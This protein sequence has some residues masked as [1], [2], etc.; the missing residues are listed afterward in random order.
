MPSALRAP[1][2]LTAG[3]RLYILVANTV[4]STRS[5]N[6]YA[7]VLASLQA[8][9]LAYADTG[10]GPHLLGADFWATMLPAAALVLLGIALF[11]LAIAIFAVMHVILLS[12]IV[13][14]IWRRCF[15]RKGIAIC[16]VTLALMYAALFAASSQSQ[17]KSNHLFLRQQPNLAFNADAHSCH[18]FGI[19]MA[20]VGSLRPSGCAAR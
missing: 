4:L 9:L 3:V 7:L 2:R 1:V 11:N 20:A 12:L 18:A 16:L 8:P 10:I 17:K 13:F 14:G 6:S 15:W 19:F 5:K